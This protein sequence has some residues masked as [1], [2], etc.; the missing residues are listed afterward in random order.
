MRQTNSRG[1]QTSQHPQTPSC[2]EL[3]VQGSSHLFRLPRPHRVTGMDMC[4]ALSIRQS[5]RVHHKRSTHLS[6]S[7][8]QSTWHLILLLQRNCKGKTT[9][10]CMCCYIPP[11]VSTAFAAESVDILVRMPCTNTTSSRLSTTKVKWKTDTTPTLHASKTRCVAQCEL[12]ISV[13]S[14]HAWCE[15]WYRFDDDK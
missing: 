3:P 6:C 1:R 13:C 14:D 2:T 7:R 11:Y 10:Q 12:F 15:Q 5:P 9:S 4:S 8:L